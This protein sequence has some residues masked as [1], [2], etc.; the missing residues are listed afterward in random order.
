MFGALV[1]ARQDCLTIAADNF[2]ILCRVEVPAR[3]EREGSIAFSAQRLFKLLDNAGGDEV[4][5]RAKDEKSLEVTCGGLFST[6]ACG[7]VSDFPQR[8]RGRWKRLSKFRT[9]VPLSH[10]FRRS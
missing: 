8:P 7:P 3:I 9:P 1:E 10:G 5:I 6:L 2:E 4:V